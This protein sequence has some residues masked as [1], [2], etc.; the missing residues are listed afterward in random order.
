MSLVP[1]HAGHVNNIHIKGIQNTYHLYIFL[2][3]EMYIDYNVC[4]QTTM[5]VHRLHCM[6]IDY[7][8]IDYNVY[9]TQKNKSST[10][11]H[12]VN[13]NN[14]FK[15]GQKRHTKTAQKTND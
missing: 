14:K 3:E 10:L 9:K 2:Y 1:V 6:Y 12:F 8:Y 13:N 11:Y 4:T 7:M 15:T 5:Y